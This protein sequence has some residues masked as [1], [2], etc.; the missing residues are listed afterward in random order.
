VQWLFQCPPYRS[1]AAFFNGKRGRPYI[2]YVIRLTEQWLIIIAIEVAVAI[3]PKAPQCV[4]WLALWKRM[5]GL[6]SLCVGRTLIAGVLTWMTLNVSGTSHSVV[7]PAPEESHGV[8][9]EKEHTC[10][11]RAST[12]G[13]TMAY[14]S[15]SIRHLAYSHCEMHDVTLQTVLAREYLIITVEMAVATAP[16]APQGGVWLALWK[17]MIGLLPLCAGRTLIAGMLTWMTLNVS[18]TSLAVVV[19]ILE[20]NCA[21]NTEG[22]PVTLE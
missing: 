16:K 12:A 4:L 6:L 8:G 13:A 10:Y 18:G 14:T 9:A 17:R 21:R 19:P 15:V 11:F 1:Q 2:P 3:A 5:V 7:A 20:E 22:V